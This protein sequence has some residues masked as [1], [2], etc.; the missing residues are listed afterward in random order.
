MGLEPLRICEANVG[1][2]KVAF[3]SRTFGNKKAPFE[4]G[5]FDVRGMGLEPT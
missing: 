4:K 2:P 1:P 5:G 3:K